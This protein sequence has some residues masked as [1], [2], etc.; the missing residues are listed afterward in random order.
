LS[1]PFTSPTAKFTIGGGGYVA[2][3]IGEISDIRLYKGVL[4]DDEIAA[5]AAAKPLDQLAAIP[6]AQRTKAETAKLR[7]YFLT[8][9]AAPE[10]QTVRENWHAAMSAQGEYLEAVPTTMIMR[11]VP[12]LRETHLLVRGEYNK[13][14]EVVQATAPGCLPKFEGDNRLDFARWLTSPA[15]PLT[16]RV[17]VNRLWGQS[18]GVGLVKTTEDFGAQGELPSHPE[19]L[20]WLAVEFVRLGWDVKHLQRKLLE[21]AAYRQAAVISPE[22]LAR[23]PDNRLLARGP[24]FRLPAEMIRDSA[25]AAAGLLVEDLGGPSVKPYQPAGLWEEISSD[26]TGSFTNYVQDEGAGLYRRG[27]YTYWKRTVSPPMMTVLDSPTRDICRVATTRTNTPLQALNMMNDVTYLEAARVLAERMI[28]EGGSQP[29]SRI[30]FGF[31][32]TLAR[33]PSAEEL[34]VLVHGYQQRREFF[35]THAEEAA[36][37]LS[38]GATKSSSAFDPTELA[39][40]TTVAA[41]LFNLDEF[42]TRE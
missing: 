40:L 37:L 42:V 8:H 1:N 41:V 3:F 18:F 39:A 26:L 27:L 32:A 28:A 7:E 13:P 33:E 12:N 14:G 5:I 10:L 16:S 15:H 31:Q 29:E 36:Q 25:L 2:P 21:S 9:R 17:A 35:A 30:A 6:V 11:D 24:R 19:L 38:Q 23:D 4:T 34:S 20:D 22:L